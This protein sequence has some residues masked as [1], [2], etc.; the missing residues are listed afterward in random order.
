MITKVLRI[1]YNQ[2]GNCDC[3]DLNIFSWNIKD[4]YNLFLTTMYQKIIFISENPR[5]WTEIKNLY[6]NQL[7]GCIV[8]FDESNDTNYILELNESNENYIKFLN[9]N[10]DIDQSKF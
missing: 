10:I 8:E 3:G 2:Y 6:T 1:K 9:D 5:D 4:R 7:H